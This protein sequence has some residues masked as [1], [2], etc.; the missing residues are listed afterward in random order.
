MLTK[1]S[2]S[3][4]ATT[5][6]TKNFCLSAKARFNFYLF[7]VFKSPQETLQLIKTC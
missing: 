3:V 6:S 4:C 5:A 1:K 7:V 2:Y